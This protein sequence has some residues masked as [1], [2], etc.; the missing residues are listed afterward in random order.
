MKFSSIA[1]VAAIA[2]PALAFMNVDVS[3]RTNNAMVSQQL[4]QQQLSMLA[5][6][7]AENKKSLMTLNAFPLKEGQVSNMFEGPTPLVKERDACGVGFIANT[8]TGGKY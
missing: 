7:D 6:L 4:D 3:R 8:S 5:Q 2:T 1:V